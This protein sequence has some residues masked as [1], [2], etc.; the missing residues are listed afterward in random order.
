MYHTS[1]SQPQLCR[2]NILKINRFCSIIRALSIL[3]NFHN[4]SNPLIYWQIKHIFFIK[5]TKI[6][7]KVWQWKEV[8]WIWITWLVATWIWGPAQLQPHAP[9][10]YL[11]T[12][13]EIWIFDIC[14]D[15]GHVKVT[16][17]LCFGL[18][19]IQFNTDQYEKRDSSFN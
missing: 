14:Q 7:L 13:V 1:S 5:S 19:E 15:P 8:N 11:M 9:H 2:W 16:S 12:V 18:V 6:I 17:K 4:C 3:L 10:L